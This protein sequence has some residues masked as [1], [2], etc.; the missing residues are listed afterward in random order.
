MNRFLTVSLAA[1]V[2]S[3][4][5]M[6]AVADPV[7]SPFAHPAALGKLV[8]KSVDEQDLPDTE[9]AKVKDRARRA[10]TKKVDSASDHEIP[11]FAAAEADYRSR[12]V[13]FDQLLLQGKL[14]FTPANIDATSLK[15]EPL[16]GALTSGRHQ[17]STWTGVSRMF[18]HQ[19]LGTVVLE[20]TDFTQG[21]EVTF[22]QEMI[23]SDISG[24]PAILISREGGPKKS[25][26]Q[27]TWFANGF[28]YKLRMRPVDDKSRAE[29]MEIARH[30][31]R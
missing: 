4:I 22:T 10:K 25:E 24:A 29:L 3:L 13:P 26:T 6:V 5:P 19:A 11:D 23:N 31:S 15:G 28:L 2:I 7:G 9:K 30:L 27:L 18:R 16:V 17:D 14:S 12:K 1:S 8:V 21:G 20:E